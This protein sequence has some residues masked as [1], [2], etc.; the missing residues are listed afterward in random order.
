MYVFRKYNTGSLK[1]HKQ[2]IADVKPFRMSCLIDFHCNYI[3]CLSKLFPL[4][5]LQIL[6][7]K[8]NLY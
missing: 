4:V 2:H 8:L 5:V 1:L 6:S 7:I 3:S